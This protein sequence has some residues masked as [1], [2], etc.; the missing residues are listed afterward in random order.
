MGISIPKTSGRPRLSC[1]TAEE[2]PTA[3]TGKDGDRKKTGKEARASLIEQSL[4]TILRLLSRGSF[5]SPIL[6]VK[7][8]DSN[9]YSLL[10]YF[11]SRNLYG[12]TRWIWLRQPDPNIHRVSSF[13]SVV[14]ASC[15]GLFDLCPSRGED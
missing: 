7:D 6:D 5:H 10:C 2:S 15:L 3:E 9:L 14:S 13:L 4:E 8:R 1:R 12:S 11:S